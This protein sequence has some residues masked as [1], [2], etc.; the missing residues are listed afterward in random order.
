VAVAGAMGTI[1]VFAL[2]WL[3]ARASVPK[4]NR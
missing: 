3:L 1:I 2:A 4:E